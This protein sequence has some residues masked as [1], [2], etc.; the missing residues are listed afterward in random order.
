MSE[1]V[2]DDADRSRQGGTLVRELL[3]QRYLLKDQS[4]RPAETVE[5][6]FERVA[7]AVTAVEATHGAAPSE[8]EIVAGQFKAL[9]ARRVFLP[10][11]PTLMNAGRPSG[12]L[13]ACFVLGIDDSIEG[14]FE[15]VKRAALIQKAGGGTGFAFDSLRPTGDLVSSSGGTTSGPMSFF[16]V[17]AETTNAIQQGARRRG[18]NMGMLSIEHPDVLSFIDAKRT[19]GAFANFNIS[20]KVT[21]AFMG[22]LRSDPAAAHVVASPRDGRQYSLPRTL[23]I[24][25]YGL[26]DLLSTDHDDRDCY[27]VRDIWNRIVVNA[28]ATGE[29]GI[30][31]IDRVNRD[32]PT[33]AIGSIEATNP[34]GEQPLL[35]EEACCLGSIDASKFVLPDGTRVKWEDLRGAVRLAVR[36]LDDVIDANHY[37][38]PEIQAATLGNRKIGLGL[39]GF[40]DTLILMGVRY[41]S[42]DAKDL[43]RR[44]SR[45][46]QQAAHDASHELAQERGC[47][48]NW[49]GSIWDT[50][51]HR[52]MRNASCTTIAPTGSISILAECSAG[53]EPVYGLAHRRRAL[54]DREFVQVHPLLERLGKKGGWL[55]AQVRNALLQGIP[56]TEISAIPQRLAETLVTAHE[57]SLDWHVRIQAAFQEHVDS[58]VSKTVNLPADATASDIGR[59]FRLAFELGCKGITVYRDGSR[60]GQTLSA[61]NASAQVSTATATPRPRAHVTA[62]RTS[63]YRMGCGTLFVTVNRDDRGLCEVFANLGK[64]GGCPSQSEATCRVV[65]VAMRS[66]V[67]PNA[68]VEQLRGIRCLSAVRAK[69]NGEGPNVLSCPDAVATAI[70]E[71][72]GGSSQA[73]SCDASPRCP[74]CGLPLRRESGCNVC[75]CGYSK[76]G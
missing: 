1:P 43:A 55:T 61:A 75:S 12:L 50:D 23:P 58:A 8:I 3:Q 34:C 39:M 70:E 52:P 65:S 38:T 5:Q 14:I 24:G 30:C 41:D 72:M 33:P 19:P 53:I 27:T 36:F 51:R 18:A 54:D 22:A 20:I 46:V 44:L 69:H 6:M 7:H 28:H 56:A 64:A 73:D 48:P 40:A 15:T 17:F 26:Q 59:V 62:G 2:R 11:S 76:C 42:D 60:D 35:S 68:L 57:V 66:G 9:M 45:F 71:A 74:D 25:H 37:P 49:Q 29:P 32:N 16:R 31:F 67:D 63:K 10:N 47:F 21:D 4:G 13:S